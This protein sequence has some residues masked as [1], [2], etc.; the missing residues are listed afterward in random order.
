MNKEIVTV[1]Q[2]EV[3]MTSSMAEPD[4]NHLPLLTTRDLVLFPGVT[5]PISLGREFSREL[6][7]MAAD[8]HIYIGVVAQTDPE[9]EFPTDQL[10]DYG[11]IA[12]VVKV[13]EIPDDKTTAI[14]RAHGK[15]KILDVRSMGTI[16]GALEATVKPIKETKARMTDKE[17][18]ALVS[19]VKDTAVKI[20]KK[21]TEAPPE[22]VLNIV[23][24]SDPT[25]LINLIA[26]HMPLPISAKT[27]ILATPRIK[28]RAYR[29]LTNMARSEQMLDIA[30]SIHDR[31]RQKISEQQRNVFL[32]QQ[33]ESIREEL[34]GDEGPDADAANLRKKAAE[35]DMPEPVVKIFERELSKLSRYAPQSPDYS[36]QLSYLELLTDLP[37]G[38]NDAPVSDIAHAHEV[39]D[40]DHFGLE[41]V[42][43][44]ILE[45]IAMLISAPSSHAPIICLVGPPGVGKTSLGQSIATALGRKYRRVALGGL[46]DEAEIRG[47]R[48]TYIGAMPGRIMTR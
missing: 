37:W 38:K 23:D 17:M 36:V 45:Q 15:C 11:V 48:R 43:E 35:L 27:E 42:K 14:V 32:Q 26:T 19:T 41:K 9:V 33:L 5:I 34:Y 25:L 10:C 18:V 47:H 28:E 12:E 13:L 39:L 8:R 40:A 22:M 24:I 30:Q 44:R 20:V 29:L 1:G 6:A 7:K 21:T 16:H 31:T 2:I 4:F 3:D 46:H